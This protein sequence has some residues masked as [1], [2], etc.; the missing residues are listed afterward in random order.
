M[1][2]LVFAFWRTFFH[3][4]FWTAWPR[5]LP[6]AVRTVSGG[7]HLSPV[8]PAK[9][10]LQF[11][12]LYVCVSFK[13]HRPCP[14]LHLPTISFFWTIS[15]LAVDSLLFSRKKQFCLDN[16]KLPTLQRH[17]GDFDSHNSWYQQGLNPVRVVKESTYSPLHFALTENARLL[18]WNHQPLFT[19]WC[20]GIAYTF[21]LAV[22]TIYGSINLVRS[23]A[24]S[25]MEQWIVKNEM[26]PTNHN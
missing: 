5:G 10:L 9:L 6:A 18:S 14:L 23:E 11:L 20:N 7:V 26:R 17:T 12:Y 16:D 24:G 25:S 8:R 15:R 22:S 4:Y 21:R 3:I 19:K 1:W 2:K 13:A